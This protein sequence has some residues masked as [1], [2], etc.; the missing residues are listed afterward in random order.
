MARI[1]EL[2]HCVIHG[3]T[4]EEAV[5]EIQEVK[6]DW[7]RSNLKRGLKIPEPRTREY[8]GQIRLRISPS[9]HRLLSIRA[10]IEN[11]SLNQY[12]AMTLAQ[13]VGHYTEPAGTVERDS[14]AKT[15][16]TRTHGTGKTRA[17]NGYN[18][19][20]PDLPAQTRSGRRPRAKA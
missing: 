1:V 4:P 3:D 6:M 13:A 2:P 14:H 12:M 16:K 5:K 8:S 11:L 10:E 15:L 17:L 9:I 7:I 20:Q 19:G 18:A